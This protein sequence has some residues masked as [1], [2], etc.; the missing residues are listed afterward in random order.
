MFFVVVTL[1]LIVI[2]IFVVGQ[3]K[4]HNANYE[5]RAS[6]YDSV[7][8]YKTNNDYFDNVVMY[9]EQVNDRVIYHIPHFQNIIINNNNHRLNN[10]FVYNPTMYSYCKN[11]VFLDMTHQEYFEF[12][13]DYFGDEFSIEDIQ[14]NIFSSNL[15]T[16]QYNHIINNLSQ[17][18][19]DEDAFTTMYVCKNIPSIVN[20]EN[21][22]K[23]EL[24][25]NNCLSE[26]NIDLDLQR[27]NDFLNN[28]SVQ[29]GYNVREP[30][31]QELHDD[32]EKLP[33]QEDEQY[34]YYSNAFNDCV[35]Q[36]RQNTPTGVE[37]YINKINYYIENN[38]LDRNCEQIR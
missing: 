34:I 36:Y 21:L 33:H 18:I 15:N 13:L 19:I 20:Q 28:L 17:R 11:Y 26:K 25:I 10:D 23:Y 35:N 12:I 14:H 37:S 1:L 3:T 2:G 29:Y 31:I 24:F 5:S 38:L 30:I 22:N 4:Y 9:Y 6:I 8:I 32:L 27:Y 16:E 7:L